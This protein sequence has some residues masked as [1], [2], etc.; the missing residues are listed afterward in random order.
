[1]GYR[2]VR[3]REEAPGARR[4]LL[5]YGIVASFFHLSSLVIYISFLFHPSVKG[6]Y[7][8]IFIIFSSGIPIVVIR[9]RQIRQG[10]NSQILFKK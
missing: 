1:M 2:G 5:P 7:E 6:S 9:R 3:E 8:D 4:G 10:S